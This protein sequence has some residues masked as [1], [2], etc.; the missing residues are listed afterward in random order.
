MCDQYPHAYVTWHEGKQQRA[1]INL[2]RMLMDGLRFAASG[3]YGN[4]LSV[5]QTSMQPRRTVL[6]AAKASGA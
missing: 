2:V 5:G 6:T 3:S 4:A 1:T